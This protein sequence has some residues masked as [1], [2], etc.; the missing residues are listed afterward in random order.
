MSAVP[1]SADGVVLC[2]RVA[3]K[4][5]VAFEAVLEE[6]IEAA[7]R[8]GRVSGEVLRGP[9]SAA[10]FTYY[11]I[12]RFADEASLRAWENSPERQE[13]AGRARA[14]ADDATHQRI[15][16][17]EAWFDIPALSQ[18]PPRHRMAMLTWLGIWPLVSLV[19]W[20]IV[21]FYGQWPFL[22]RTAATSAVLVVAMTYLVMPL[23]AQ[24]ASSWLYRRNVRAPE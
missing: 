13:L 3:A 22:A 21:P 2:L 7:R 20:Y 24:V 14:L 17:L 15:T 19:L 10:S 11:I 4:N 12:Y 23:L 6:L 8:K 18:A 1:V 5:R 16:G 9:P